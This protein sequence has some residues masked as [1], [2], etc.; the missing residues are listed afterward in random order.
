MNRIEL[1]KNIHQK[2]EQ[3]NKLAC[4]G[5]LFEVSQSE[6]DR[7]ALECQTRPDKL[8]QEQDA[9]HWQTSFLQE[10]IFGS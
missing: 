8:N 9:E 6:I 4:V 3:K 10:L 5:E 1:I 7:E 2:M